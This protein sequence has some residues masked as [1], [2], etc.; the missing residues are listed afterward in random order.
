MS[1]FRLYQ[2]AK[3]VLSVKCVF[4]HDSFRI[5]LMMNEEVAA[6]HRP[7]HVYQLAEISAERRWKLGGPRP[8]GGF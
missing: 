5:G 6:M 4:A 2:N 8:N 1:L 3:R 7:A